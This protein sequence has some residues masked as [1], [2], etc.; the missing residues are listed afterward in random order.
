[1]FL[2]LKKNIYKNCGPQKTDLPVYNALNQSARLCDTASPH[3][4]GIYLLKTSSLIYFKTRGKDLFFNYRSI[5]RYT[6]I[7]M[8]FFNA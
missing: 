3:G 6:S 1:M 8:S 7:V 4:R 5:K 2:D